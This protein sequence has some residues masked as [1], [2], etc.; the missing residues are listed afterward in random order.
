VSSEPRR[1]KRMSRAMIHATAASENAANLSPL[2]LSAC[3]F[4]DCHKNKGQQ[5]KPAQ[6]RACTTES[7]TQEQEAAGAA[8]Q[9]AKKAQRMGEGAPRA[10][11]CITPPGA[12]SRPVADALAHCSLS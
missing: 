11:L 12:P 8:T 5:T 6:A 1:T 9:G 4:C 10:P 3:A 7:A 2:L